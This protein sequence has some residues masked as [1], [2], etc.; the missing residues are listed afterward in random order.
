MTL[1]Q[2]WVNE[3]EAALN[4][5]ALFKYQRVT[6]QCEILDPTKWTLEIGDIITFSD[7]PAD[8]RLRDASAAYT[9]YQFRITETTRTVNS[10]KIKAMEVHKA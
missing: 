3:N 2:D 1:N 5:L 10:L 7:P 9:D 8:F 6:A 4:L